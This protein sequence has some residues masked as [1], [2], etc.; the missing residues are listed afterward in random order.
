MKI[1]PLSNILFK[2][3]MKWS[4]ISLHLIVLMFPALFILSSCDGQPKTTSDVSMAIANPEK[5]SAY[6]YAG[7]A[8]LSRYALQQM[9]YG[10]KR[11]GELMLIYVTEDFLPERQVKD[12]SG[13]EG[14]IKILKLNSVKKFETGIYDYSV[15]GST[16]TPIDYR[17]FPYTL[18]STF[19]SQDWCGQVFSQL[20]LR[21]RTLSYQLRSYFEQEGDVDT[22]LAA[23]YFEED[24]WTRMRIE[25]QMLPLGEIDMIPAQE[26]LR[27]RHAPF[28][29]YKANAV[30]LLQVGDQKAPEERYVYRIEF[31]ELDRTVEWICESEFPFKILS[32]EER[33][34]NRDGQIETT[35]AELTNSI[36]NSYWQRNSNADS[37]L[38]DTLQ[39]NYRWLE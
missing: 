19:S 11:N 38:R 29:A 26:F 13:Q 12:E 3:Q 10:E 23:T 34:K 9:R 7:E 31:P 33:I 4:K 39:L 32:W 2:A 36:K 1:L 18:K 15:M 22:T 37:A 21:E 17:R 35:S 16:F 28:K 6:W 30:L 5:F 14:A 27:L 24:V 20:N 8:E 25:P